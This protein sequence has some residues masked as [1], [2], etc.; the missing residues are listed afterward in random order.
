MI[1][2]NTDRDGDGDNMFSS[3]D[4]M[5]MCCVRNRKVLKLIVE[6]KAFSTME[7]NIAP[8]NIS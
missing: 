1:A 6:Y 8:G 4:V 7:S 3:Y 2:M 5:F